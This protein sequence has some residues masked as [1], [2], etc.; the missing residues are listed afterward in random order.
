MPA[1]FEAGIKECFCD[2]QR[3]R[4][5]YEI[6]AKAQHIGIV[7]KAG[8]YGEICAA[9]DSGPYTFVFIGGNAHTYA[10]TA[11]QYPA[12]CFAGYD[13]LCNWGGEIRVIYWFV[14]IGAEIQ[15]GMPAGLE[16]VCDFAFEVDAAMIASKG[17]Y[18]LITPCFY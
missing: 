11:N 3:L 17:D 5:G 14:A 10:R 7:V 15:H 16:K 8:A 1:T 12:L 18:H 9:A 2:F 4:H 6:G 13:R